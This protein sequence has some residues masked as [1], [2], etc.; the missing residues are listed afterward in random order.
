MQLSTTLYLLIKA[1]WI[2]L[3]QIPK[4]EIPVDCQEV[5]AKDT[6]HKEQTKETGNSASGTNSS[7][8]SKYIKL[9]VRG[10]VS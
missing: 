7:E 6:V 5:P 3:L 1:F 8:L 10:S 2:F 9:H 4:E